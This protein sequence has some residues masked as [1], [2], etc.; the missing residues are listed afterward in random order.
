MSRSIGEEMGSVDIMGKMLDRSYRPYK[1][2]E[3]VTSLRR[4]PGKRVDERSRSASL[5]P[6][7]RGEKAENEQESERGREQRRLAEPRHDIVAIGAHAEPV[8]ARRRMLRGDAADLRRRAGTDPEDAAARRL[9]VGRQL[10][11]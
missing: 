3:C 6:P 11:G 2:A 9:D 5:P 8:A 4:R 1:R 10:V 7:G